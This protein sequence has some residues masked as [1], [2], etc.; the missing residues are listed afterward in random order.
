MHHPRG[1][2]AFARVLARYTGPEEVLRLEEAVHKM[3][4]QTASILGLDDSTRVRTPR[5]RVRGGYAADLLAF[6]L[7]AV[8]D[9]AD[10]AHPH[11]LAKGM[12]G[13]WVNGTRT[14][15]ADT[16]VTSER[17]GKVLQFRSED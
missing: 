13:V 16:L 7:N 1:Y 4:G 15:A 2:G 8:Q 6:D 9:R 5:G 3:T 17:Q 11:R 14:W 10:F 12:E